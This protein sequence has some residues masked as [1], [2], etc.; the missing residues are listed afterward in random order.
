MSI[1]DEKIYVADNMCKYGGSFIKSLGEALYHADRINTIK[2]KTTW[3]SEWN[4]YLSL[5]P[6]KY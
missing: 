3:E 4:K 6:K 1:E 2:I 5:N